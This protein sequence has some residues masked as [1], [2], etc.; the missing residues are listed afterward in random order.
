MSILSIQGVTK[1]FGGLT[2][3]DG[4]DMELEKGRL[5]QLIGPNGSGKTTLI[6]V[7]S[8]L[9]KPDDGR[10]TFDGNDITK[11]GLFQ[12]YR[13]GLVRTFQIPQPFAKLTTME[14]FLIS[15]SGNS[16][17]SFLLAPL[18]SRWL[19]DEKRIMEQSL[20]MLDMVNLGKQ[21]NIESQ[22]LSGGQ[23][24]LLELG[25]AMMSGNQLLG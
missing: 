5:Y 10:I 15:S 25:R 7:I 20:E 17:E 1:H 18:K 9:L 12:T 22:N 19:K 4:V 8:G 14:N 2:V 6:N 11:K 23:L 24:K 3:L 13:T 21:K 16:G